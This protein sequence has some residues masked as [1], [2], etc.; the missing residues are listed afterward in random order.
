[1]CLSVGVGG[2]WGEDGRRSVRGGGGPPPCQPIEIS[3]FS[4]TVSIFSLQ[5][6]AVLC[7]AVL[8]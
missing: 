7:C 5:S 4:K 6:F 2:V 8:C 1:M 3:F